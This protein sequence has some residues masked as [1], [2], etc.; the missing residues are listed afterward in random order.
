MS[1]P[2]FRERAAF[3]QFLTFAHLALRVFNA[4]GLAIAGEKLRLSVS[5]SNG[6]LAKNEHH[7]LLS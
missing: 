5:A 4:F 6:A 1:T 2:A 7:V 3:V